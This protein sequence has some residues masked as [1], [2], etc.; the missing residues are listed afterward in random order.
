MSEKYHLAFKYLPFHFLDLY[1]RASPGPRPLVLVPVPAVG[2]V[3]RGPLPLLLVHVAV[4]VLPRRHRDAGL[5]LLGHHGGGAPRVL[6]R[7]HQGSG[8]RRRNQFV[9]DFWA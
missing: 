8:V 2:V 1:F 4:R 5:Q 7:V 6:H 9:L 3:E